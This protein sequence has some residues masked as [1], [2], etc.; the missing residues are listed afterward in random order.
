MTIAAAFRTWIIASLFGVLAVALASSWRTSGVLP[1]YGFTVLTVGAACALTLVAFVIGR[2]TRQ[3]NLT[4][5]AETLVAFG[6]L[7]LVVGLGS[8]ILL[9]VSRFKATKIIGIE[10]L[11]TVT[12]VFIEGLFTAAVCPMLAML[13]R[14]REAQLRIVEAGGPEMD[15]AARAADALT[16]QLNEV[17]AHLAALNTSLEKE[18][19]T[20]QTAAADVGGA[21]RVMAESLWTESKRAKEALQ[22]VETGAASLGA[23]A[24]QT[25]RATTRLGTDLSGL[26]KSA[27]E[28]KTLLDALSN[29]VESVER[30]VKVGANS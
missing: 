25:G 19:K 16:N 23:A 3:F 15:A 17:T 26:T 28:A 1:Q 18:V 11:S 8:A 6:V 30:F 22:R 24:E 27:S 2:N 10:D 21:A 20:F 7:S 12:T 9:A 14:I 4:V 29:A 13:I 5:A